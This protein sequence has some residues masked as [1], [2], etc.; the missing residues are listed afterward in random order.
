MPP[1]P[2]AHAR[3]MYCDYY[4]SGALFP[5]GGAC[6]K[7]RFSLSL[8]RSDLLESPLC[9]LGLAFLIAPGLPSFLR[10]DITRPGLLHFESCHFPRNPKRT[11]GEKKTLTQPF[12]Y[13][14]NQPFLIASFFFPTS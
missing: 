5:V 11:R 8:A 10:L 2:L 9:L 14:K 1:V 13:P 6:I 3:M 12:S 4:R 7:P